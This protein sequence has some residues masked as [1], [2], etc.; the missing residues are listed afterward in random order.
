MPAEEGP[1]EISLVIGNI[2]IPL[3]SEDLLGWGK[4]TEDLSELLSYL[5]A[6][7]SPNPLIHSQEMKGLPLQQGRKL[8]SLEDSFT[9]EITGWISINVITTGARVN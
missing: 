5:S 2:A 1:M 4:G 3:L 9:R 7:A 6:E 8:F